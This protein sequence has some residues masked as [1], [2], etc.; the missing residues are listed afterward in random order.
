[1]RKKCVSY[2][3]FPVSCLI[4]CVLFGCKATPAR[5]QSEFLGRSHRLAKD[6]T[7]KAYHR[8]WVDP[9]IKDKEWDRFTKVYFAPVN[10]KYLKKMDWWDKINT[11]VDRDKSIEKLGNYTRMEFIK[12]HRN[13]PKKTLKVVD[14]PDKNTLIV[15]LAITEVVPTKVWLNLAGY[16]LVFSAVDQG[17]IAIEGRIKDGANGKVV[18]MFMDREC[19]RTS[20]LNAKDITWYEHAK[21]I[22]TEWANQSVEVVNADEHDV[23]EDSCPFSLLPW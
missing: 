1:M 21:S 11:D 15:E 12:A 4:L 23:V 17:T 6:P 14:K 22:I 10:T 5:R 3:F 20:L 7:V 8:V 19:G 13:N 2:L 16:A 9:K 18:A